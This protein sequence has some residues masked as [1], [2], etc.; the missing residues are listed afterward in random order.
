MSVQITV[1]PLT[2]SDADDVDELMKR[3]SQTLGFL[4]RKVLDEYIRQCTAIGAKTAQGE[5]AGYLLYAAN[6][7]RFRV[8]HL[9][10][11]D[12]FRGQGI[13]RRLIDALKAAV[14][15]QTGIRLHCRRDYPANELWP[16][17]G[18]LPLGERPARTPGRRLTLWYL[19]LTPE[20]RLGLFRART[21]DE[22]VDIVVDSQV[23]F[24]LHEPDNDTTRVSKSLLSDF[25][26]D[27]VRI[28]LTDE[29]YLEIDRNRDPEQRELS[30]QH[31]RGF[32]T[33]EY[34]PRSVLHFAAALSRLLPGRTRSQKSD[35]QHLAKT[36]ASEVRTFVTRDEKLLRESAR[37][38][39]LTGL[40]VV[41][42]P[43]VIVQHHRLLERQSYGPSRV[44]G[45][46]L[47]W[48]RWAHDDF[49]GFP[50]ELFLNDGER[51]G[52]FKTKLNRFFADPK[53]S[54]VEILYREND[55]IAIRVLVRDSGVRLIGRIVRIARTVDQ[56][57]F[58]RFVFAD[59]LAKAVDEGLCMVQVDSEAMTSGLSHDLLEAGFRECDGN[60]V[61]FTFSTCFDRL[62]T[63]KKFMN[64]HHNPWT[65]IAIWG[66]WTWKDI[67]HR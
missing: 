45:V 55:A 34:D 21:S 24:D 66:I 47:A 10:V 44:A 32:P 64:C 17:L 27:S 46:D 4:P 22:T 28:L 11:A 19:D 65:C 50:F 37:I 29:I 26:A 58:G 1:S 5:L 6:P 2:L 35:I 39:T 54:T 53:L 63:L 48:R 7:V 25:M 20:D 30:R 56:R 3:N 14:T 52:N 9:C 40:Q 33:A 62:T 51:K 8:A 67:A 16:V 59:M 61:K 57:Q 43:D 41:S 18:F 13:A 42:P 60:F 15:T 36:A 12:A 49:S 31:A 23:F 38:S